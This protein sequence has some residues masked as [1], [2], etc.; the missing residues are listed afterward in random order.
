MIQLKLNNKNNM[1]NLKKQTITDQLDDNG[2]QNKTFEFVDS[3]TIKEADIIFPP[4][5]VHGMLYGKSKMIIGGHSKSYKSWF[6]TQLG[7]A[8][9]YG[10][11]FIG[12]STNQTKVFYLNLE[13]PDFVIEKRLF[14]LRADLGITSEE[15]DGKFTLINA[16]G[17]WNG[18]ESLEVLGKQIADECEEPPVIVIDPIYKIN[19]MDE[20]STAD[21]SELFDEIDHLINETQATVIMV[22]HFKKP[23]G[24]KMNESS[25]HQ[26]CGSSIICRDMDTF[27]GISNKDDINFKAHFTLR[28]HPRHED[29]EVKRKNNL[30]SIENPFAA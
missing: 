10:K 22:H 9:A 15:G 19:C 24:N 6:A 26:L 21:M 2:D 1:L 25:M 13:L 23:S 8:I 20:N 30:F 11:K 14:D 5:V 3:S 7:L 29:L 18:L 12:F 16:R 27:V 17:R 28:G 4:E